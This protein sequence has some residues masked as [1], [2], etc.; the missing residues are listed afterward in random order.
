MGRT[1]SCVNYHSADRL[2]WLNEYMLMRSG[3]LYV[4]GDDNVANRDSLDYLVEAVSGFAYGKELHEGL[5]RKAAAYAYH[6]ICDHVFRDGNKRT[7]M[8]AAFLFLFLNGRP[9][10]AAT[11]EAV[12]DVALRVANGNMAV[13]H[14]ADWLESVSSPAG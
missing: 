5:C 13:D 10:T 9:V 6:I 8:E 11:D 7:G 2:I 14:L 3:G 4:A 12:V 1:G